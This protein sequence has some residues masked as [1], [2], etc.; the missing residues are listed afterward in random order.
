MLPLLSVQFSHSVVSDSL[1]PHGLQHSSLLC[2]LPTPRACANS[3]PS[4]QWGHP[5]ISSSVFPLLLLTSIFPSIR[6]FSN[7]SVLHI[8][9]P[10]YWS[11]SFSIS[12]SNEYSGLL[13]FGMDWFDLLARDSQESSQHHSSKAS[14]SQC[15]VFLGMRNLVG[16]HLWGHTELDTTEATYQQQQQQQQQI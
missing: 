3:C 15:S 8:M 7:E 4:S 12:P 14:I 1:W 5:T 11:F 16:C 6:V 2:P 13:F 10:K 9:R